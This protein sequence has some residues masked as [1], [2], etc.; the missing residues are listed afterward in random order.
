MRGSS[1]VTDPSM[2]ECVPAQYEENAHVHA[3]QWVAEWGGREWVWSGMGVEWG[4]CG[5]GVEWDGCGVGWCGVGV[6]W[7]GCGVGWGERGVSTTMLAT[8]SLRSATVYA[9]TCH[10]LPVPE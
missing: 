9:D 2:P 4:E 1:A 6:E 5:V 3:L 10:T 7:D 8:T